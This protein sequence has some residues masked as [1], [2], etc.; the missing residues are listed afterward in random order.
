MEM[1]GDLLIATLAGEVSMPEVGLRVRE[2]ISFAAEKEAKKILAS[3]LGLTGKLSTMDRYSLAITAVNL[4]HSLGI[5]P[6]VAF[7]GRPPTF[8]GFALRVAMNRGGKGALFSDVQEALDWL[9]SA[10]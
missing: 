4:A 3:C 10:G 2:V 8:D 7:V 6:R 5:H 1:Q 9:D